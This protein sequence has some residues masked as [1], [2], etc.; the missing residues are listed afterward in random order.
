MPN[1]ILLIDGVAKRGGRIQSQ[2]QDLHFAVHWVRSATTAR[3]L[4]ANEHIDAVLAATELDDGCGFEFASEIPEHGR[5]DNL[6][7][8]LYANTTIG[9]DHDRAFVSGAFGLLE[10]PINAALMALRISAFA[11]GRRLMAELDLRAPRVQSSFDLMEG[12]TSFRTKAADISYILDTGQLDLGKPPDGYL[13]ARAAKDAHAV[14]CAS[15]DDISISLHVDRADHMRDP[16][17]ILALPHPKPADIHKALM[18]GADDVV[19][20]AEGPSAVWGAIRAHIDL[21]TKIAERKNRLSEWVDAGQRDSLTEVYSRRFAEAYLDR[22]SQSTNR[23][24]TMGLFLIDVNE[25]KLVNDLFGHP[26][27][28]RVL[29]A[30]A[31][32]LASSLRRESFLARWGGDEFLAVVPALDPSNVN[33]VRNRLL[34][35]AT[36]LRLPN[37]AP[38]RISVGVALFDPQDVETWADILSSADADLYVQKRKTRDLKTMI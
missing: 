2:F 21:K 36:D 28:D 17:T 31:T 10:L 11:R 8:F 22:A 16:I 1:T 24:P 37:N 13:R 19:D 26:A 20:T 15:V 34:S 18:I 6:P 4:L 12:Q 29:R 32:A 3:V 27:G 35:A 14:I 38:L 25:F 23:P 33:I 9:A 7:V 30:L 5:S